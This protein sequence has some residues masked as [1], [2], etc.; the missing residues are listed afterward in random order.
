MC[1]PCGDGRRPPPPTSPV[2]SLHAWRVAACALVAAF[3]LLLAAGT[4]QAQTSV[5]LVSNIGQSA[6]HTSNFGIDRA[7]SF[8]TGSNAEGY[9][10]TSVTFPG[11]GVA[12]TSHTTMRIESSNASGQPGGSLGALTFT[13]DGPLFTGTT[14]GIDLDA[15]TTYFV[16]LESTEPVGSYTY[17]RTN[18]D[19][20]DSGAASGWSIGDGSRFFNAPGSPTWGSTSSTSWMI[21]IHGYAKITPAISSVAIVSKPRLDANN[22][23]TKETYGA[24]QNIVVDVTWDHAVTWDTSATNAGIGVRLQIGSTN[25][26]AELVTGGATSGTAKTLRFR[27]AVAAADADTDGVAVVPNSAGK[28]AL[29]R[30]GATLKSGTY[31]SDGS[32]DASVTHAGLGAQ[33]G[34]LVNGGSTAPTNSAPTFGGED[35]GTVNA[36]VLTQ[37]SLPVDEDDFSDADGDPLT[38]RFSLNRDDVYVPGTLSWIHGHVFFMARSTCA[39]ANL[40][41]PVGNQGMTL[42]FTATDPDGASGSV[43]GVFNVG[44]PTAGCPSFSS[45]EVSGRTLAITLDGNA[46]GGTPDPDEF[47]VK[48]GGTAVALAAITPVAVSGRTVTLTLAGTPPA[49]QTV[50]VSYTPDED[51]M[52]TDSRA[53]APMA[54]AFTDRTVGTAPTVANAIPDQ[55]A[56]VGTAF[57]FQ[58]AANTFNDPDGDTLSYTATLSDDNALPGW[59]SFAADTRTFSGT[60]Q[61]ANAGTVSVKVT[62]TDGTNSVSDTFDIAVTNAPTVANAIPDQTAEPGTAF[63]FQFPANTFNDADGDTLSYTATK[64]D[65]TALPGWLSFAADTRTFSGT[66]QAANAGTVSVKVT[67]TDGTHSVSDSF[68]IAVTT[69]PTVA[70]AIPD[71]TATVNAAFS[72]QFAANTFNDADGDTLTYTATKGDGTALP[73]WL[74]FAAD[75]RTFSGTPTAA[76]VGTVSV[77]VTATDGTHSVSDSFDIAVVTTIAPTAQAGAD[78]TADPGATVTLSG[79]GTDSDGTIQGYAWSQVSGTSV[80]LQ[81]ANTAQASFTAPDTAGP[82]VFRLTVTDNLGATDTDDVTVTVNDVPPIFTGSVPAL[83]LEPG[84]AMTPVVLPEATGGN[85]GPYTYGLSSEPTGLAGLSF[86]A[87]TRTLSG[88]PADEEGR[89]TFAYTAHDGDTVTTDADAARLTFRVTVGVAFE[90]QQQVARRTLAAVASR[91]VAGALDNIGTRL[92]AAVP[93]PG[94]TLA[95]ETVPFG[96]SGTVSGGTACSPDARERHGFA[97]GASGCAR[98]R[99]RGVAADTVLPTSAFSLTLGAAEGDPGFDPSA[100]RWALWGR[101]DFGSFSGRPDAITHYRGETRTGWLGLDAREPERSG[102]RPGRWVAGLAIS[103]GSSKTDYDLEGEKGRIETDLTAVWPYGRWSFGNGLELRGMLGAGRGEARHAADDGT[104]EKSRLRMWTVAAGLRRPL[105]PV[106]GVAL[107]AQGDASFARMRT[108]QGDEAVDGLRADTWRLRVGAEASRRFALEDGALLTPFLAASVRQDGGDGVTGTGLELAGGLRYGSP[109][110]SVE[111]RV[112]WLVAHT[113]DDTEER[114]ASVTVRM[115]PAARGRGIS[116]TLSPRWGAPADGAGALWREELPKGGTSGA[117]REAGALDLRVGYGFGLFG[118]RFTGTPNAGLGLSDGGA[119]DYRIG[120]RLTPAVRGA[121]DFQ[122]DLGVT[123]REPAGGP[124]SPEHAVTLHSTIH[125]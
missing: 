94:L 91:A 16:V 30:N 33:S 44:I 112:R 63:S 23:G 57:S 80:T 105:S 9:K 48:V 49:D 79:S 61:A 27:Y 66:P 42:T 41:P 19:N 74:S 92:G 87:A 78:R 83:R 58:F 71:Q 35:P 8:T 12:R 22:D 45:A 85:G 39:L 82:L 109:G 40:S 65:G 111:A 62:A 10:L 118:D 88:T 18:S 47:E 5:T 50:T 24:G 17:R 93:A 72:F 3:A 113:R 84:A 60:P 59:L 106:G 25:R 117:A 125:W 75:T 81:N 68:D 98:A 121:P 101:G 99:S 1:L 52:T 70:N 64:A 102:G 56:A 90:E 100:P 53:S 36:P 21:A 51:S 14:T 86:D 119:R 69:A 6:D 55:T 20:E 107:A 54:V 124:A 95:G 110:V 114:G 67:A 29:L 38:F 89:W 77:K 37:V 96:V 28:L 2:R 46:I 103:R 73:G 123:R 32:I 122:V 104:R 4:A 120:W 43:T 76:N 31:G 97:T 13:S 115:G 7:Q 26:R 15:S 34:H 108:A 11:T 116:L